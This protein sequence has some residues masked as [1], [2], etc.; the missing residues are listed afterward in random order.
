[1]KDIEKG[2]EDKRRY[3]QT[4]DLSHLDKS[5]KESILEAKNCGV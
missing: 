5:L 1:M 2:P 3:L 4:L